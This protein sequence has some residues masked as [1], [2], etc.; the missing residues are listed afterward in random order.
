MKKM[1]ND[2]FTKI[3]GISNTETEPAKFTNELVIQV[4]SDDNKHST[5]KN[6]KLKIF[7]MVFVK[8]KFQSIFKSLRECFFFCKYQI[9]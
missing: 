1:F 8:S 2:C 9:I 3:E 7:F 6:N 5:K 4:D